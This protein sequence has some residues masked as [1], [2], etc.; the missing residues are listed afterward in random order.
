MTDN[1]STITEDKCIKWGTEMKALLFG[2]GL[3]D[4]VT[5]KERVVQNYMQTVKD[6]SWVY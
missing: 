4:T 2:Y 6:E 3:H 1:S 5:G